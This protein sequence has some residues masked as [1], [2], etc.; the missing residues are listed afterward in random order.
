VETGGGQL[1][2]QNAEEWWC[3]VLHFCMT[4]PIHTVDT[5]QGCWG[6]FHMF[7]MWFVKIIAFLLSF[8]S[9]QQ[10]KETVRS[11]L[12]SQPKAQKLLP[13]VLNALKIRLIQ[14]KNDAMYRPKKMLC[15]FQTVYSRYSLTHPHMSKSL[16]IPAFGLKNRIS[17]VIYAVCLL[18]QNWIIGPV[19]L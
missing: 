2:E 10:E 3:R 5:L 16:I 19:C 11:W 17:V 8:T 1:F 15:C 12:V 14:W 7:R 4:L 13:G 9:D 6:T 18:L